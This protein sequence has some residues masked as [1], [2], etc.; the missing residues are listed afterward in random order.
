MY[1]VLI[2]ILGFIS[3]L[4]IENLT[5]YN[6]IL[7]TVIIIYSY[8]KYKKVANFNVSYLSGA[9]MGALLMFSN[10][11]Y[12]NVI[13][14]TD[15]YRTIET[16][17]LNIFS[18]LSENYFKVIH[19]EMIFDNLFLNII[20]TGFLVILALR[21]INKSKDKK[22]ND[23]LLV[24]VTICLS[25]V[26]YTF[27]VTTNESWFILFEYTK[28]FEGIFSL[29]YFISIVAITIIAVSNKTKKIKLFFYLSTIILVILPLLFITPIGSRCFLSTYIIFILYV[30]E[31]IDYL[32]D[33]KTLQYTVKTSIL[34]TIIF[35]GFL[36]N[37]YGYIFTADYK[38]NKNIKEATKAVI[39]EGLPYSKYVWM[40]TP[41]T[42]YGLERCYKAFYNIDPNIKFFH[43]DFSQKNN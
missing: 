40:S 43:F 32:F 16:G 2:F 35:G 8:K 18:R 28:Y 27:I 34:I 3:A 11:T 26:V 10:G 14:G 7:G 39:V 22:L 31:L 41:V 12:Q 1:C 37:V 6:I 21:F 9:V 24:S 38:R 4:F 17:I 20:I 15:S 13:E 19:K 25:Y 29:L 5:I 33:K 23:I 42:E 30:I 36:L